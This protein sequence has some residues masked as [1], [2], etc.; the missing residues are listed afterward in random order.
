MTGWMVATWLGAAV[1]VATPASTPSADGLAWLSGEWEQVT[2]SGPHVS[3]WTVERWSAPRGGVM[4]GTSLAGRRTT[5]S[6]T[7][8]VVDQPRS[9]EFLRIS[10]G[11]G[12]QL[13]YF[14]SPGGQAATAFPL[15]RMGRYEVVFE[16]ASHD[17]PQRIA[18][19]RD[20]RATGGETLTATISMIDG[21]RPM[22]WTY[23]RPASRQRR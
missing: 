22:S 21:S 6:A 12:G 23:R 9:F 1:Q 13:T 20:A 18:Y 8:A 4:L 2:Q 5:N 16:N 11:E 3:S 17:Y 7:A 19:R 10:P 15:A 14:A